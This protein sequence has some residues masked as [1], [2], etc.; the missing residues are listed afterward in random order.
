[1]RS[2]A[3]VAVYRYRYTMRAYTAL[4]GL[5]MRSDMHGQNKAACLFQQA[6]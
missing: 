6:A 2:A 3:F 4:Y 1:M 5:A